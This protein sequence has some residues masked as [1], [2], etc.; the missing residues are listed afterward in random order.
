MPASSSTLGRRHLLGSVV[1]LGLTLIVLALMGRPW[2]CKGGE[3]DL[4][5]GAINSFHNSQ[6][7]FD[8]YS[9]T[10]VLHG[11]GFYALLWLLTRRRWTVLD[12]LLAALVMESL[13][14]IVENTSWVI[15]RYR[16]E[17]MALGY[18]GDSVANSLGDILACIAGFALAARLPVW[19]S[20]SLFIAIEA[21]LLFFIRD[22]LLLNIIMLLWP[23]EA[24]KS[25]QTG[26][27]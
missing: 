20:I 4:W 5:S 8:P 10:H 9:F 21:L 27:P 19:A 6:H 15:E 13:W 24:I 2:W 3:A 17:T 7:L 23:L 22:N 25:W 26:G 16:E 1:C 18:Y 14:E 11:I 12:R